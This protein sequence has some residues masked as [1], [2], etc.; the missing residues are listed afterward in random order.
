MACVSAGENRV[1]KLSR[2]E[3]LLKRVAPP[4][5][6]ILA[7]TLLV[8]LCHDAGHTSLPPTEKRYAAAKGRI[9]YLLKDPKKNM[10]RESWEKM[11]AEFRSIYDSDP[12]W[13]NRPAALFRAAESLEELAKRSC[14]RPD[15]RKA[16][17]CYE[18]VAL[19]HAESRLADDAL[20]R[21]A[22]LRAAMLRDDKGALALISRIR[23]QY[24]KGDKLA[25]AIALEK[26]IRAAANGR[27]D[28][29]AVRALAKSAIRDDAPAKSTEIKT[30]KSF[31]GDLPLRLRAAK[32]RVKTLA[33][34]PLKSCWRQPW[35]EVRDE[36]LRIH[37]SGRK[38]LAPD[39]LFQA[40][41]AQKRLAV[42]SRVSSDSKKAQ[43]LFL[44]TAKE[45]PGHSLAADALLEAARLQ[46]ANAQA[47]GAA[48]ATL[49]KIIKQ[50]PKSGAAPEAKRLRS[51]WDA[52]KAPATRTP[53]VARRAS[54]EV[55]V[56]SWNSPNK[57]SVQ[58]IVELSGPAEYK[59]RLE[60]A[61]SGA[62]ATLHLELADASVVSD[63]RK[64]V[65]VTG[66]LL[67][68]VRVRDR[69]GGGATLQFDF[70]EV[71]KFDTRSEADPSRIILNVAAGKASLPQQKAKG[72]LQAAKKITP[73]PKFR[74]TQV[75]DIASQLGLTVKRIFIDAGHGG[76]DPGTSHNKVVEKA[77]TLDVALTL[78]ALLQDNGF[79]VIYSRKTDKTL[80]LSE[81]TRM[82]NAAQADLFVSI[83][84]NANDNA[85]ANGFETYYLDLASNQQAA[86]VAML[87]NSASDKRL[88]DMQSMLA[89]VMLHAKAGEARN[90]ATDIQRVSLF[91]L[92]KRDYQTR[93]NGVK[94]APF[95]VLVGA[96]MPA[97]LV[98]L[99]YCSNAAEAANLSSPKYR[100]ALAEGLAESI[101][102][103]RD[104]LLRNHTAGSSTGKQKN[105]I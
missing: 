70:R 69:K 67:K 37:R 1:N 51:I 63:V 80:G 22:Q 94:S 81:R 7:I 95:H 16:V 19:R 36:F 93:S 29:E 33:G 86:R 104:R 82:A 100:H 68:A 72:S 89:Q 83:H 24:P 52:A 71:R 61:A 78:G 53:A 74:T 2:S 64:G 55:Q 9:A 96:R 30:G 17:S 77:I 44:Q 103:Y 60:K 76:K 73:E 87:E 98:E 79:E 26:A 50:Y 49:D 48:V 99:G 20:L 21:A 58:I 43:E 25:E 31:A 62:P 27:T 8:I 34:D 32:T 101:M 5:A 75:C 56:L 28:P 42:C 23:K 11:A 15:A 91:R 38:S 45:F 92:K 40:A 41:D 102:A 47:K 57:N 84:V 97:V 65:T 90:L 88:R 18:S 85:Q 3:T 46:Y 6:F 13:P 4:L 14:S 35:E 54:P 12:D 10:Q 105:K 66:S 39:A 59:A